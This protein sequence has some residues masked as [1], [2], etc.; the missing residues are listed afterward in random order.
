MLRILSCIIIAS[1]AALGAET[2]T[3]PLAEATWLD[4]AAAESGHGA[5]PDLQLG[6]GRAVLLRFDPTA[7]RGHR[8][9]IAGARLI[10][11]TVATASVGVAQVSAAAGSWTAGRL[12]GGPEEGAACWA[13]L[14]YSS[15]K[16]VRSG[17]PFHQAWPGGS[18]GAEC[19]G[20]EIGRGSGGDRLA[21][22][23]AIGDAPWTWAADP[24][25]NTGL[26]V[27]GEGRLARAGITLELDL[28]DF[29][30]APGI[31]LRY[32]LPRDGRVS[33]T[34]RDQ[35]GR[36]VRELLHA[37][38]RRAGEQSEVWDGLRDDGEAVAPGDYSWTL[39][40]ADGLQAEYLGTLGIS[41]PLWELWP[42]NHIPVIGVAVDDANEVY[43]AAG[44]SES[45]GMALKMSSDGERRWTM[46]DY[47]FNHTAW[48][49]GHS[50]AVDGEYLFLLQE[51]Y[52][53]QR[54][55]A[56]EGWNKAEG[57]HDPRRC[58]DVAI[59]PKQRAQHPDGGWKAMKR[60][61]G[62]MTSA[63]D[64]DVHAGNIVVAYRAFDR[65][66]WIDPASKAPRDGR[67]T[68]ATVLHEVAVAEP[69]GVAVTATGDALVIS[70]G[71][72]L[73]VTPQGET[74]VAIPA[75][76]LTAPYRLGI[77]RPSG[78][79]FV[80]ERGA[81]Q[82]VVRFSP[83][84][85]EQAR[86]GIPGGRPVQGLYDPNGF[87]E[88]SDLAVA[89]DGS[90]WITEAFT[91]PRRTAHWSAEGDLV[92]EWY[93]G[94]MYANRAAV[95]PA[96]PSLVWMDSQWGELIQAEVDWETGRWSVRA[97]YSYM[98]P[99][100]STYRH[101]T[102]LWFVRHHGGHT[103]LCSERGVHVLRLDEANRRLVPAAEG[104]TAYYPGGNEGWRMPET[105]R[106]VS[107]W[108]L[109]EAK[110]RDPGDERSH[111]PWHYQW[112]DRSGDGVAQ[113][114]ELTFGRELIGLPQRTSYV[115]HELRYITVLKNSLKDHGRWMDFD[116]NGLCRI[117]PQAWVADGTVPVYDHRRREVLN[118]DHWTSATGVWV[119]EADGSIWAHQTQR[120]VKYASDGRLLFAVGR[121]GERGRLQP[122]E[123][124]NLYRPNG[125]AKGCFAAS[126]IHDGRNPVWTA[127]GLWVGTL[128]EQP[129]ITDAIPPEAYTLC[130]ENFGGYLFEHPETGVVYFLGGGENATPIYRIDG[131]DRFVYRDGTVVVE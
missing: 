39:L 99:L 96:D 122:G 94:Q 43:L 41:V 16:H 116:T 127:D 107:S 5:S 48:Q 29:Q 30:R 76:R 23:V 36:I 110:A 35:E 109:A 68:T 105:L 56:A 106:D 91:A 71:A 18:W 126:E 125:V 98:H 54:I 114:A 67:P 72:I 64:F 9:D 124:A 21:V 75:E 42:G 128:L 70:G 95:D 34:I 115:D 59:D 112:A 79:I 100:A 13:H 38:P 121:K 88:I 84:G 60:G 93:G 27:T 22:P 32:E 7:L 15:V 102:G 97:T 40:L 78:S 131:F 118:A 31:D 87:R 47:W 108:D 57:P 129:V 104:G 83:E 1:L 24:R 120:V 69:E 12:D 20:P 82:Q 3:L 26:A 52:R 11:P 17:E 33:L 58:W 63:V 89:A 62:R 111:K 65:L 119:D 73:R 50:L 123:L 19:I 117:A 45:H 85:E 81:S 2:I 44:C 10:L 8:G 130:G 4:R 46:R 61:R 53:I 37:A 66:R 103:W 80:A 51:D 6:E 86:F 49:G 90:F 74:S 55:S 77:H 25:A 101:E 14:R 92:R 28:A 113:Q